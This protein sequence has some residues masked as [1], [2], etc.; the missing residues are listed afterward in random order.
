MFNFSSSPLVTDQVSQP[1]TFDGYPFHKMDNIYRLYCILCV[2]II[3][4]FIIKYKY[5]KLYTFLDCL[6][7]KVTTINYIIFLI[8]NKPY[9]LC[10]N[11]IDKSK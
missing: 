10:V 11:V 6:M 7:N 3:S 9:I 4:N 2:I 5:Y 8:F 1:F